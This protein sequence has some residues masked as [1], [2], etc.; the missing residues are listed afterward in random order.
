MMVRDI[1]TSSQEMP[2]FCMSENPVQVVAVLLTDN[3]IGAMPVL[4]ADDHLV[5]VISE[6]DIM[7]CV[8]RVGAGIK[9]KLVTDIMTRHVIS[10]GPETTI[11]E[12]KRILLEHHIRHLVIVKNARLF[13]MLSM[14]DVISSQLVETQMEVNV[15]RN[16]VVAARHH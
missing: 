1:V 10:C 5:G 13:G 4:D 9:N 8:A 3:R 2:V 11:Q 12:A 14:R 15:L 7:R 6:R 16:S